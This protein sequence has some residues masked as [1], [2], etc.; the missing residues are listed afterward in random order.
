MEGLEGIIPNLIDSLGEAGEAVWPQDS[1]KKN[2]SNPAFCCNSRRRD[3]KYNP[4]NNIAAISAAQTQNTWIWHKFTENTTVNIVESR[5]LCYGCYG[6]AAWRYIMKKKSKI[7]TQLWCYISFILQN[8]ILP[9]LGHLKMSS[10]VAKQKSI[11]LIIRRQPSSNPDDTTVIK[12]S[13]LS[14][15]LWKEGWCYFLSC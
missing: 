5:L 2:Y 15:A 14:Q 9:V 7:L 1:K 12:E 6:T 4:V 10:Q 11:R 3:M 13:K 8:P